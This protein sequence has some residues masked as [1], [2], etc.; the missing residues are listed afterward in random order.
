MATQTKKKTVSREKPKYKKG[1]SKIQ[2]EKDTENNPLLKIENDQFVMEVGNLIENPWVI[3]NEGYENFDPR[4]KGTLDSERLDM[5]SE[6]LVILRSFEYV[7]T[8]R[9]K[10]T[11]IWPL[12]SHGEKTGDL[13]FEDIFNAIQHRLRMELFMRSPNFDEIDLM[14][15]QYIYKIKYVTE[16]MIKERKQLKLVDNC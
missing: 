6:F 14:N 5:L 9:F 2:S 1:V 15:I 8:A 4:D 16:E 3:I 13:S 12:W 10:V 11:Y 7:I